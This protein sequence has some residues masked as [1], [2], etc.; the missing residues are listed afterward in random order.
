MGCCG[1]QMSVHQK[2]ALLTEQR[3]KSC[4]NY[5]YAMETSIMQTN[6]FQ[7]FGGNSNPLG[8]LSS[9]DYT[10]NGHYCRDYDGQ[11]R[12]KRYKRM[13]IK[14][15]PVNDILPDCKLFQHGCTD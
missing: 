7:C 2:Q 8:K 6:I 9:K 13:E 3:Y 1:V 11:R 15:D 5:T 12:S 4:Q 10:F 14:S